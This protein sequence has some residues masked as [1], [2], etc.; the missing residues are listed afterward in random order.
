[1]RTKG[2]TLELIRNI[3]IAEMDL[4]DDRIFYYNQD[5]ILPADK[6]LWV[7]VGYQGSKLYA[8]RNSTGVDSKGN[9]VERQNVNTQEQITVQLMSFNLDALQRKEEVPQALASIYSQNLQRECAFKIAPIMNVVDASYIE[10]P[11]IT[12]RFD[13]NI[14]VLSWYEKIKETTPLPG[15]ITELTVADGSPIQKEFDPS[16]KPV[17]I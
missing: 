4:K 7:I 1:M 17:G 10:G 11:E 2:T 6:G 12:Y 16:L 9:F 13:W 3:L 14:T 5:Y 8:N 15:Y